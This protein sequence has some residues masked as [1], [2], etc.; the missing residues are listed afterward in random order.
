LGSTASTPNHADKPAISADGSV[1]AF[2]SL[3]TNLVPCDSNG[4]R[5]F[6]L[7]APPWQ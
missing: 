7:R 5:D 2:E 6:F 4:T 3:A 1:I